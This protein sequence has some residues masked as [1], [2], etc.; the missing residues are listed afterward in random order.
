MSASAPAKNCL[1]YVS[2]PHLGFGWVQ[3]CVSMLESFSAAGL[4]PT[5]FLPRSFKSIASTVEV[6]ES[7][8]KLLPYRY[9]SKAAYQRLNRLFLRALSTADPTDTIVYFWPSAPCNL[10]SY[11]RDRGFLTI[12]EMINNCRGTT[13][14]ILDEAYAHL[15]LPLPEHRRITQERINEQREELRIYDYIMSC[16]PRVERS[17]IENGIDASKILRS[18]FGW[19]PEKLSPSFEDANRK[20]LRVLFIGGDT[21]RKGLPQLLAAW[22]Q[23]SVRGELI[24]V[25]AIDSSL[26]SHLGPLLVGSD[27]RVLE[28]ETDLGRLYKSADVFV[29]PSL[30]EGDPQVTYEA[31]GCGL[32]I[33]TTPMGSAQVIKDGVNGF[34]VDPYDVEA[35]AQAISTLSRCPELRRRFGR[36]AAVDAQRFT[37]DK[38]GIERAR[39]LMRLDGAY[40]RRGIASK[41][42]H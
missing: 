12:G 26:K 39:L 28:F 10:V 16:N 20:Q 13:K 1:I 35:L 23:S 15:G 40:S 11:S 8:P 24:I 6:K 27:I 25:G 33:I 5:L 42:G 21:V 2:V 9:A 18:S 7:L 38:V 37:Y 4:N 34:V 32:P 41:G 17:L 31:A 19:S 29:F 36:R 3:G 30:E 22:K 14:A